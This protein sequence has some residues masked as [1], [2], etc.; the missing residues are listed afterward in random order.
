M[1]FI[2]LP[3]KSNVRHI[4]GGGGEYCAW[5]AKS[6]TVWFYNW[7][8]ENNSWEGREQ[9]VK[10]EEEARQLADIELIKSGWKLLEPNDKLLALL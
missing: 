9:F 6:E 4:I 10:T 1:R 7:L 2:A 3:W 5:I 8:D